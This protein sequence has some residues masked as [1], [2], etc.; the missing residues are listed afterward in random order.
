LLDEDPDLA[1]ALPPSRRE[2]AADELVTPCMS[3]PTGPWSLPQLDPPGVGLI[4]L[5][6]VLLRHV[7]IDG[8]LGLELLGES[9]LVRP[10]LGADA[11]MI[12]LEDEWSVLSAAKLAWLD[13]RCASVLARYPELVSKLLE[14]A[15]RRSSHL[16]TNLAI[17]HQP[18]VDHRLR[19]LMWHLAGR[20][21]RVRTDGVFLPLKLTH[22]LLAD[23][24][25]A[26]RPTV[27]SALSDLSRR[28]VLRHADDGWLLLG[29]PPASIAPDSA[30]ILGAVW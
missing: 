12:S 20:W 30:A 15:T 16:V 28:G 24:V 1:E 29:D 9:D 13:E 7:A 17:V 2:R 25:A 3:F 26:R 19:L 10:W 18:R 5:K 6:G 8:R 27:T 21:G 14:R 11:Q 22:A 4:V 23:L